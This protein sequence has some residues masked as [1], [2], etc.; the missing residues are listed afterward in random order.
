MLTS[1]DVFRIYGDGSSS[2]NESGN[3]QPLYTS[4]PKT[5]VTYLSES[6]SGSES[7][8][9]S[10]TSSSSNN[11]SEDKDKFRQAQV[12][13][14]Q[15]EKPLRSVLKKPKLPKAMHRQ[16]KDSLHSTEYDDTVTRKS[17]CPKQL[18]F[19][20][21]NSIPGTTPKTSSS[22]SRN[23]LIPSI[24]ASPPS[25]LRKSYGRQ[26][27]SSRPYSSTETPSKYSR[28][29]TGKTHCIN[30]IQEDLE[31]ALQHIKDMFPS[32]GDTLRSHCMGE[33]FEHKVVTETQACVVDR[34]QESSPTGYDLVGAFI[35]DQRPENGNRGLQHSPTSVGAVR[36]V[37][38]NSRMIRSFRNTQSQRQ[39]ICTASSHSLNKQQTEVS[40]SE[41]SGEIHSN[42]GQPRIP[43][44]E[45]L[46]NPNLVD[47]NIPGNET[48]NYN[49]NEELNTEEYCHFSSHRDASKE[50]ENVQR[51]SPPVHEESVGEKE[52]MSFQPEAN[53]M[54]SNQQYGISE[55]E[56]PIHIEANEEDKQESPSLDSYQTSETQGQSSNSGISF[57]KRDKIPDISINGVVTINPKHSVKSSRREND[58]S[59][60]KWIS[61]RSGTQENT[62]NRNQENN[63]NE[64][65]TKRSKKKIGDGQNTSNAEL[66]SEKNSY[67]LININ[68]QTESMIQDYSKVLSRSKGMPV[69]KHST[70]IAPE[71]QPDITGA[72]IQDMEILAPQSPSE[73]LHPHT[74]ED[75][76]QYEDR[77]A[78]AMG[79][80]DDTDANDMRYE[81]TQ[82]T[83]ETAYSSLKRL[84]TMNSSA[85]KE[86]SDK[87]RKKN[88]RVP[89]VSKLSR[90]PPRPK[91]LTK[92][93]IR[94]SGEGRPKRKAARA[95]PRKVNKRID[96][97]I[98]QKSM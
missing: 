5:V 3:Q 75:V 6:D 56:Q 62:C 17:L 90:S 12:N 78:D 72:I 22:S 77:V 54:V 82:P 58:H 81:V 19:S 85:N 74:S 61:N 32:P 2:E 97:S 55:M 20:V 36:H 69:E 53:M 23:S 27:L 92:K 83:T 73:S 11:N 48:A 4:N 88:M 14:K 59:P 63:R 47:N 51:F 80:S 86:K 45:D 29:S 57:S 21:G 68:W 98:W 84:R 31:G 46:I 13:G 70:E 40:L 34:L 71:I 42:S 44:L 38:D 64:T 87:L 15:L 50:V 37:C 52:Q 18:R 39:S 79:L 96:G 67:S 9:S 41:V 91:T 94:K 65:R 60:K 8:L 7:S 95:A 35:S 76:G 43:D 28:P 10:L 66:G 1:Q 49:T 93:T 33:Q 89:S 30:N 26:V 25:I 16:R 24:S